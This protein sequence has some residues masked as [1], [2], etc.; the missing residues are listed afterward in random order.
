M[1][2]VTAPGTAGARGL[3]GPRVLVTVGT[4]HHPFDRLI[5][6]IN[7][8]LGPQPE[9]VPTFFV[10][11][12]SASV[13]PSCPGSSF[14]DVGQLDALLDAADVMVCHGGP[15]SIADAW[16]RG[17]V[18]IVVPRLRKLGEVVDDHQVDFCVK[19][20]GLGRVRLAQNPAALAGLLDEAMR[21]H[22]R[23]R[24]SNPGADVDAAVARF[25]VVIDE[26]MSRPRHRL[27]LFHQVRRSRRRP[28]TGTGTPAAVG[29]LPPGLV[30]AASTSTTWHASGLSADV[31]VA[32]MANEEQE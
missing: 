27:A 9:R 10:Q 7:A 25:G 3:D 31:G 18:P 22:T 1:P 24:A 20:A 5:E 16:I 8:W 23:F 28:T 17:Q 29:N 15:G 14:L 12:G 4:D 2:A 32:G 6:W 30:P 13:V 26:L 19:L 21:D 11:S